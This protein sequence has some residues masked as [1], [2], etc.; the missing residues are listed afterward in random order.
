[1]I[2]STYAVNRF[3]IDTPWIRV[4]S[5]K[6][7]F[8]GTFSQNTRWQWLAADKLNKWFVHASR[9]GT[10]RFST[11]QHYQAK[12]TSSPFISNFYAEADA[13]GDSELPL[14]VNSLLF[15]VEYFRQYEIEPTD[16]RF[17]FTGGRSFHTELPFQFFGVMPSS[18][19]HEYWKYVGN[20]L[21][22]A[23]PDNCL[24]LDTSIYNVSRMW[25]LPNSVHQK[26]GFYKI[27]LSYD[28]IQRLSIPEIREMSRNPRPSF[29]SDRQFETYA[30]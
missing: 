5:W 4:Q 23:M 2:E 21:N 22:D 6:R 29:V 9:R 24:P 28:E 13:D 7:L 26:R 20:L 8:E 16:F 11:P 14:V 15:I 27:E 25:R 12:D 17:W 19:L 10:P 1:M 30:L 18:T 3:P